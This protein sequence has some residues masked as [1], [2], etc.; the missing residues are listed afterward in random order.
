MQFK[1]AKLCIWQPTNGLGMEAQFNNSYL[2]K[3]VYACV[4]MRVYTRPHSYMH[5]NIPFCVL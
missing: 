1:Q 5:A 4:Y 3:Y 2:E